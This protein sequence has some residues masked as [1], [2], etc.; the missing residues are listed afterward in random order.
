MRPKKI[1]LISSLVA[2]VIL[3][4][5]FGMV[6]GKKQGEST[7]RTEVENRLN[8]LINLA[9]PKPPEVMKSLNG[10]VKSIYGATINLEVRDPN[11]YLPHTD[12]TPQRTK[13]VYAS[14]TSATK[15]FLI[16]YSKPNQGSPTTKIINL[17]D[18]K[19]GD[20]IKV[21]SDENIRDAQRFDVTE[22]EVVRY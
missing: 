2:A 10:T 1:A 16:D 9:F 21:T 7:G 20:N 6:I 22:V 13:I 14:V 5:A 18:I 4:L 8:P 12:G 17:S 11:D 3:A 19:V 15:Y